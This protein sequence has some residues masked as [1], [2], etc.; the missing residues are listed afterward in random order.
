MSE[1]WLPLRIR[2]KTIYKIGLP[3]KTSH[4]LPSK[5]RRETNRQIGT[6]RLFVLFPFAPNSGIF[7]ATV[8]SYN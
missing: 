7:L 3:N 2:Q 6:S 8:V 5:F 1:G 4:I